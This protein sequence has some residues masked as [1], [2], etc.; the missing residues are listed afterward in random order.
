MAAAAPKRIYVETF[1]EFLKKIKTQCTAEE[2]T[3]FK[4][5]LKITREQQLRIMSI[6]QHAPNGDAVPEWLFW[7]RFRTTASKASV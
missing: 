4:E 2:Y 5:G 3:K 1:C 7:R 6:E